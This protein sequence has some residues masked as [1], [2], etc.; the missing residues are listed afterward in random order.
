M[1]VEID[2]AQMTGMGSD[3]LM[4]ETGDHD[5][6]MRETDLLTCGSPACIEEAW[7][8]SAEWRRAD[9]VLQTSGQRADIA[10]RFE[11]AACRAAERILLSDLPVSE[12]VDFIMALDDEVAN[13]E[14]RYCYRI[15]AGAL[16]YLYVRLGRLVSR[17]MVAARRLPP[18]CV[19]KSQ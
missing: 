18:G 7:Q 2:E 4:R 15:E 10:H 11:G 3:D 19:G 12:K 8:R 9:E 6:P 17:Y 13:T 5:G 14:Y 1:G 16:Q